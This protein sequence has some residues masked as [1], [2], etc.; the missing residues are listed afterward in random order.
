MT[1]HEIV[2]IPIDFENEI[3]LSILRADKNDAEVSGN[4]LWKLKYNLEEAKKLKAH[5]IVTFGGAY[6]NHIY[7]TAY[8]C[9]RNSLNSIGFIRGE[10]LATQ[11]LNHTL[12]SAQ[13]QGMELMFVNRNEYRL[14]E[15]SLTVQNYLKKLSHYYIIPE[16]GTNTLAIQGVQEI[17]NTQLES[18]DIIA[19]SVG[20]GGT[21]AGLSLGAF[22]HQKIIGFPALKNASF[23]KEE[24]KKYSSKDNFE[25]DLRYHFGGYGKFDENLL[26]FIKEMFRKYDIPLDVVYTSKMLYGIIHNSKHNEYPKGS[27]ILAIHTGGMQGNQGIINLTKH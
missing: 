19:S 7:A 16:G 12:K 2:K 6:S 22:D 27:R 3:S 5:T 26:P 8:A 24:I 1:K 17:W 4:K 11:P 20:T 14:K 25:L 13:N 23:L 21:L 9:K 18:F 10:E 15:K